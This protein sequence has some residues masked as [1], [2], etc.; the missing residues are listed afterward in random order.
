[1]NSKGQW[2]P[3]FIK[4]CSHL[5]AAMQITF[6]FLSLIYYGKSSTTCTYANMVPAFSFLRT[7]QTAGNSCKYFQLVPTCCSCFQFSFHLPAV[8]LHKGFDWLRLPPVTCNHTHLLAVELCT[9]FNW[10]QLVATASNFFVK[11]FTRLLFELS[12][13]FN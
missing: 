12:T 7:R 5:H 1:M 9:D 8:G 11:I 13:S 10:L 4:V 2:L 3:P 6:L